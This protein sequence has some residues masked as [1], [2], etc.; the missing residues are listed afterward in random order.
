MSVEVVPEPAVAPEPVVVPVLVEAVVSVEVPVP[1]AAPELSEAVVSAGGVAVVPEPAVPE[2]VVP[3]LVE[4]VVSVDVPP[5]V[6]VSEAVVSDGGVG[7]VPEAVVSGAAPVE[8]VLLEETLAQSC[9]TC[10]CCSVLSEVQLDLI[11]AW[12]LSVVIESSVKKAPPIGPDQSL[13]SALSASVIIMV[14]VAPGVAVVAP[15]VP[16]VPL[17]PVVLLCATALVP[18]ASVSTEAAMSLCIIFMNPIPGSCWGFRPVR[19]MGR[20][21]LQG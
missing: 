8:A 6:V 4:A 2:P 16:L 3:V 9:L 12:V 15:D 13:V 1:V 18:S 17:V 5:L 14:S 20:T 11:S 7:V 21:D 19:G 10:A